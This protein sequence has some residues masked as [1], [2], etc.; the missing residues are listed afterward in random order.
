[1][2]KI[3]PKITISVFGLLKSI[4]KY[5]SLV[6]HA[7]GQNNKILCKKAKITIFQIYRHI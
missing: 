3:K 4:D 6:L 2:N 5:N 1:M 7:H